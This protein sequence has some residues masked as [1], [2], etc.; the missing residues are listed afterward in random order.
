MIN[1]KI[2][3][4][5]FIC[6]CVIGFVFQLHQV[7][8][9]YF[10][11][12]TSSKTEFQV[13]EF[14]SYQTVYFCP[15]YIDLLDRKP[16]KAYGVLDRKPITREEYTRERSQL[17]IKNIIELTPTTN[18]L[19]KGC[20]IRDNVSRMVIHNSSSCSRLFRIK[21]LVNGERIC[22]SFTLNINSFYS[23][24]DA[25]SSG[26]YTNIV[27]IISLPVHLFDTFVLLFI[28]E[29]STAKR[30]GGPL[31]SRKFPA[32]EY[33]SRSF[34]ASRFPVYGSSFQIQRL[35][36]PFD[37]QCTPNHNRQQC[38]EMCLSNRLVEINRVTVSGF[39]VKP[40]EFT[41][42]TYVNHDNFSISNISTAA[43][44]QCRSRCKIKIEC[45]T[46]FSI[47]TANAF[48]YYG[49]QSL[50]Y[51]MVPKGPHTSVFT[52]PILSLIEYIIRVGSCIGVWFGLSVIS[53]NPTRLKITKRLGQP[54]VNNRDERVARL[55]TLSGKNTT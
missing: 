40:S 35:A 28:S 46:W 43:Y 20:M 19:I 17:N 3:S 36:H 55:C 7:S 42:F 33:H 53:L 21:K 1:Y 22:Y 41:M 18:N 38:Y 16:S 51:S 25:A 49:T 8:Q 34:N 52:V 39:H 47:T 11:Y 23:V 27:Y 32:T 5:S 9:L 12:Q 44:I 54:K 24:G 26:I 6:L 10:R 13:R 31:N 45:H 48:E 30:S 4:S 29:D 2:L 14:E 15:R 50:I 37:T